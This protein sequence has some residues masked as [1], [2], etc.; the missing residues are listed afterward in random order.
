MVVSEEKCPE[1]LENL[2]GKPKNLP[3]SQK[4]KLE[5]RPE[6]KINFILFLIYFIKIDFL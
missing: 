2:P 1:K 6:S 4:G 5:N 3:R